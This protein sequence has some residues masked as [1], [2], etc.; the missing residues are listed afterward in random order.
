MMSPIRRTLEGYQTPLTSEVHTSVGV[1]AT[2]FLAS[3]RDASVLGPE[4]RGYRT[5]NP[6]LISLTPTGW[7]RKWPKALRPPSLGHRASFLIPS[8]FERQGLTRF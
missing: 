8:T 3:L 4:H 7:V 2:L 1:V 5:L 6:R